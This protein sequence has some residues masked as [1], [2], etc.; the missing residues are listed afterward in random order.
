MRVQPERSFS[1]VF[2]DA[3]K[4]A[5]RCDECQR[6]KVPQKADYNR[7][8]PVFALQP[9]KKWG[10]DFIGPISPAASNKRYIITAT[11]YCT[12]WVEA[13]AT[14]KNDART[15]AKFLYENMFVRFGLAL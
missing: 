10:I 14:V 2:K 7:L 5:K 15:T 11:D 3:Q 9:F 12:K 1:L 4:Y 8:H 6:T 13:A